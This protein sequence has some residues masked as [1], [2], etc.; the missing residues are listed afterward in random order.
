MRLVCHGCG[1]EA[2]PDTPYPFRCAAARPGDDI[3]H[4]ITRVL[5]PSRAGFDGDAH[6]SNPFLRY[7]ARFQAYELALAKGL[8]DAEYV[9]LVGALD[10]RVATVWGH[11]FQVTPFTRQAALGDHLGLGEPGGVWVKDDTGNVGGS[12]KARHLMGLLIRLEVLRRLGKGGDTS[13]RLA[14]ASCGNAALAAAVLARA[15]ERPLDVFIPPWANPQVVARLDEL[16]AHTITC[17]RLDATPGD[18]CYHRFQRAVAGGA[19]PF[20]CQG[21]DNGLTIEG[22]ETLVYEMISALAGGGL[23]RV[24]IQVGG[25]ALASAC[26]QALDEAHAVGLLARRPRV[27]A[28]QT[29]GAAPLRRAYERVVAELPADLSGAAR[30]QAVEATLARAAGRRSRYMWPWEEEPKSVAEGILDDETYDWLPIVRGMLLS[31]GSPLVVDEATLDHAHR[32]ARET[33]RIHASHTGTAGLAGLLA[34]ARGG[35][36]LGKAERVCVLFTGIEH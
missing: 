24:F 10:R 4:L 9:D 26:V 3:D 1:A 17:P 27:H 25:G 18:P 19:L 21:P 32:L 23:D 33:T 34:L 14:I 12:H 31:G 16:G 5:P 22:G 29:Q 2:A 28:V 35:A 11:G 8:G 30:V 6:E 15:A 36:A 13:T 20:C 7:R